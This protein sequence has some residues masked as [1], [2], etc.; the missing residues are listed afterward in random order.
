MDKVR[1]TPLLFREPRPLPG[2]PRRQHTA[3]PWRRQRR[4]AC[5][6]AGSP[7]CHL[8]TWHASRE[9]VR[10]ASVCAAFWR[11]CSALK[12]VCLCVCFVLEPGQG[13]WCILETHTAC[14]TH[15]NRY[16]TGFWGKARVCVTMVTRAIPDLHPG[17]NMVSRVGCKSFQDRASVL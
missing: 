13:G 12:S 17:F 16:P 15:K 11:A 8:S 2:S 7:R 14:D 3:Q 1:K 9:G 6:R 4:R 5:S 10:V